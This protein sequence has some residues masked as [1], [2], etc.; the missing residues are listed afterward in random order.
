MNCGFCKKMITPP[1][2]T[3]LIG[4]YRERL[5]KGVWDDLYARAVAFESEGKKAVII[6]LDICLETED[7]CDLWRETVAE[8]CEMDPNAVFI[9]CNHTHT[10]PLTTKDFASDKEADPHYMEMLKKTIRDIAFCAFRDAKPSRFFVA[11]NQAKGISFVRRY[12]MKDGSVRTN[13]DAQDPNIDHVL[14]EANET[15]K[16]LK[17]V[18][19]GGDDLFLFNF[20]T[21]SDTVNGDLISADY[22][23]YACAALE[24]A[25]PGIQA[26]FILAPQGDVNHRDVYKP[27]VGL[28]GEMGKP[29]HATHMGRVIA[30]AILQVCDRATEIDAEGIWFN[31]SHVKV[32]SHQ[33]NEKLERA[34]YVNSMYEAGRGEEL[35]GPGQHLTAMVAE[36]RRVINLKDGPAFFEKKISALRVGDMVFAGYAGEPFT[37]I[38]NDTEAASPFKNI[39]VCALVN[40]S[41]GY[42]PS[43]QAYNEGGYEVCS[44][45]MGPGTDV[46]LI[47][48]MTALLETL[49]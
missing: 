47:Q 46:A 29:A 11:E 35:V 37:A 33:E 40:G 18:R 2:G 3:P 49:K 14:A 21:H 13:P 15:V 44:S 26:M 25:I 6:E 48:G 45:A 41:G 24:G 38:R 28:V 42:Y 10:G 39:M 30:G 1:L 43:T 4:Y 9:S 27:N 32:P 34:I 20:G 8:F 23:G 17:I 5:A 12:R 31:A 36:A 7:I 19:E 22:S 16:L